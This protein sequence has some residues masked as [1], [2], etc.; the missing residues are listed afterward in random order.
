MALKQTTLQTAFHAFKTSKG[1]QCTVRA[2]SFLL[3]WKV[4]ALLPCFQF[5][6]EVFILYTY[7]QVY[8]FTCTT[9]T[10]WQYV[11]LTHSYFPVLMVLH[12]DQCF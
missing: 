3:D 9:Y 8:N 6:V 5:Q 11:L 10:H 12:A 4:T 1:E 7:F 2:Y